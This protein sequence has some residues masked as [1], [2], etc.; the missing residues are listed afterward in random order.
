MCP[1][2]CFVLNSL[3]TLQSIRDG[4]LLTVGPV[5]RPAGFL[6]FVPVRFKSCLSPPR[7]MSQ[8]ADLQEP[9]NRLSAW[10]PGGFSEREPLGGAWR[11]GEEC[12]GDIFPVLPN[13]QVTMVGW[14]PLWKASF[15]QQIIT[16]P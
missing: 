4:E 14:D 1:F 5:K 12:S 16:C 6:L 7:S 3:H 8:A 11:A 15:R 13:S 10:H 2:F 9:I